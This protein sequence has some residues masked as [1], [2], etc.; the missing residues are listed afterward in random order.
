MECY[1]GMWSFKQVLCILGFYRPD[2]QYCKWSVGVIGTAY[3]NV[4]FLIRWVKR[5]LIKQ[6]LDEIQS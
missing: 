1:I 3:M 6:I 2:Q 5:E 4:F